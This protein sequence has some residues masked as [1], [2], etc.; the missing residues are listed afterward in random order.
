MQQSISNFSMPVVA[1][2]QFNELKVLSCLSKNSGAMILLYLK[3]YVHKSRSA[4]TI[5]TLHASLITL[6]Q[7]FDVPC[8][9]CIMPF[10]GK[11]EFVANNNFG[12]TQ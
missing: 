8:N 4:T 3:L 5:Y 10:C 1:Q 11:F 7:D 12:A 9:A 2:L 6:A